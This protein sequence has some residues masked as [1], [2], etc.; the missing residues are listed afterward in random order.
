MDWADCGLQ[1]NFQLFIYLTTRFKLIFDASPWSEQGHFGDE[2]TT[3]GLGNPQFTKKPNYDPVWFSIF[4]QKGYLDC[5][6]QK[7][8]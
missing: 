2:M 5:R 1:I 7:L 6:L 8:G 3:N 4:S